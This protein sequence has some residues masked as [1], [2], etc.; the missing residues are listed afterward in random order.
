MDNMVIELAVWAVLAVI[1]HKL[2]SEYIF[3]AC[4]LFLCYILTGHCWRLTLLA[5]ATIWVL[6]WAYNL[7][8]YMTVE[9]VVP[10]LKH[11]MRMRRYGKD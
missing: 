7:V 11:V 9:G 3:R 1:A 8:A 2:D 10:E 5:F 6:T 4:D